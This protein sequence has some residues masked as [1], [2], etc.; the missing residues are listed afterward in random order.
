MNIRNLNKNNFNFKS[1]SNSDYMTIKYLTD[2]Y[3]YET[4]EGENQKIIYISNF[5]VDLYRFTYTKGTLIN[6]DIIFVDG[7][8]FDLWDNYNNEVEKTIKNTSR[9]L[10]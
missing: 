4:G 2:S 3:C 5:L 8:I 9:I 10:S 6:N 7:Y 1:I